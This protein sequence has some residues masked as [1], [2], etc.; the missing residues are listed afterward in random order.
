MSVAPHDP[1][2]QTEQPEYAGMP[3]WV[4]WVLIAAAVV[5]LVVV[6]L[7]FGS[8]HGPGRHMSSFVDGLDGDAGAAARRPVL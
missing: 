8:E 1:A 7:V 6:A 2:G 4:K 3:T 5:V